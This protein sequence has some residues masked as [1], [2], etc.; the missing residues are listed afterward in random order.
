MGTKLTITESDK[1]STVTFTSKRTDDPTLYEGVVEGIVSDSIAQA[2]SDLQSYNEAV[3]LA[4]SSVPTDTDDL[5]FFLLR[6]TAA[7]TTTGAST[8]IAF[9]NEWISPG[10]ISVLAQTTIYT[11]DVY[12]SSDTDA[13]TIIQILRNGGYKAKLV[14]TSS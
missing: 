5:T 11:I 10:S 2:F 12:D 13:S 9:A 8:V 4:D 14:S 3:I 6:L 7:N 1:G